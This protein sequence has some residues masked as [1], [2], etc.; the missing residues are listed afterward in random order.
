MK[1]GGA[2]KQ[3]APLHYPFERPC[4]VLLH[5][6][7]SNLPLKI[8]PRLPPKNEKLK[9]IFSNVSC[10]Q[11]NLRYHES[12]SFCNRFFFKELIYLRSIRRICGPFLLLFWRRGLVIPF[13]CSFVLFPVRYNSS[14]SS[15][16][17]YTLFR[18]SNRF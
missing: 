4:Q 8:N 5:S 7:H 16:S 15:R 11:T 2:D 17:A 10:F 13:S 18:K 6:A 9:K 1:G 3:P 14:D 12:N